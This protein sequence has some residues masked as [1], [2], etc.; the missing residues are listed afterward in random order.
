MATISQIL[1]CLSI[2]MTFA[3]VAL[4]I[5]PYRGPNALAPDVLQEI[6]AKL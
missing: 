2:W 1:F 3:M 6:R 4:H 5:Q